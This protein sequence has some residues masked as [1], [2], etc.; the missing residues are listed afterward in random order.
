MIKLLNLVNEYAL[1]KYCLIFR[2]IATPNS[3]W[4]LL[5]WMFCIVQVVKRIMKILISFFYNRDE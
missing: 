3:Y 2:N 1:L 5:Q 4:K